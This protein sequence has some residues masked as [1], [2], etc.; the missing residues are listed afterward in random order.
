MRWAVHVALMEERRGEAHT[1]FW[2]GNRRE[3]EN[4]NDIGI[5]GRIILK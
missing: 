5:D 3:R 1:G 2:W 4:F